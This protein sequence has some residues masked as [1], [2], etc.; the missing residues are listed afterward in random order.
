MTI[1]ADGKVDNPFRCIN[2][3]AL[4]DIFDEPCT[5]CGNDKRKVMSQQGRNNRSTITESERLLF[6][7]LNECR[8][9]PDWSKET[10]VEFMQSM[11]DTLGGGDSNNVK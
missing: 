3:K 2:C 6:E 11:L 5:K 10:L 4:Q 7:I 9:N 8:K 1:G